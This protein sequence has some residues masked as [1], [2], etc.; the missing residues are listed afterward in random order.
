MRKKELL[1]QLEA[2]DKRITELQCEVADLKKDSAV[3]KI[4]WDKK[5]EENAE[6]ERR[7]YYLREKQEREN[8]EILS[9]AFS[10]ITLANGVNE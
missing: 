7:L 4:K 2:K 1:K 3:W 8:K 9:R 10:L 5:C 6:T